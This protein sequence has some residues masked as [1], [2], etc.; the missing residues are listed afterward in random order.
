MPSAMHC[1]GSRDQASSSAALSLRMLQQGSQLSRWLRIACAVL[2]S[3]LYTFYRELITAC[4]L[5]IMMASQ[6][7]C[8][9]HSGVQIGINDQVDK[10]AT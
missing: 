2:G 8:I 3:N 5:P 9:V 7:R 1:F 10:E 4:Y 6:R